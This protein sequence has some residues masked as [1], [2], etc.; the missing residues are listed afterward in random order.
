[1]VANFLNHTQSP[2]TTV[3]SSRLGHPLIVQVVDGDESWRVLPN[4]QVVPLSSKSDPPKGATVWEV[5]QVTSQRPYRNSL[6]DEGR[7]SWYFSSRRA[8]QVAWWMVE[9]V[10][11]GVAVVK[12]QA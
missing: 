4:G 1:M 3:Q 11:I 10:G 7:L 9:H 12:Y 6:L 5:R 2:T 8:L